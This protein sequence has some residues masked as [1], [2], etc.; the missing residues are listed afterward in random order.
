MIRLVVSGALGRMGHRILEMAQGNSSFQI[1]GALESEKHPSLGTKILEGKL[2]VSSDIQSFQGSADV[3]IDFTT[4]PSTL[5]HLKKIQNWKG[6]AAVV[7]TTG[8]SKTEIAAIKKIA[9]KIPV[10]LS[11]NMS[12]GINLLLEVVGI[13]AK[14]I[15]H[16]DIEIVESHHN[17]KKDAPSGT[18]LA[19]AEEI[20]QTLKRNPNMDLLYGRK[21]LLCKRS[22]SDIGIH[23]IRAGDIVGDHTVLFA[24]PGERIELTHKASSRDAFAAGALR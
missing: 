4:P 12:V 21:V 1:A 6:V 15:P 14:K 5:D 19:L 2:T 13:V 20:V 11:P 7:G 23:S 8:F 24:A 17:Q 22:P 3:L 18:A 16:Y 10:L 9:A